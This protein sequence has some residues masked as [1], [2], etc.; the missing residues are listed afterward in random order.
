MELRPLRRAPA[1]FASDDLK[2]PAMRAHDDGLDYAAFGDAVGQ[3]LQGAIV[4]MAARLF[5]MRMDERDFDAL[6]RLAID[7]GRR[8]RNRF[9]A[10][11]V[12]Q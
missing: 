3:F 6:H 2:T 4:K 9:F 12:A 8:G 7:L 11:N 5:G 1:T 10:S